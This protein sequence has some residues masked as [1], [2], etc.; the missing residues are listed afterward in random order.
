[1]FGLIVYIM[2]LALTGM[3]LLVGGEVMGPFFS[4][5]RPSVMKDFLMI[6]WPY[7]L[8]LIIFFISS[9]TYLRYMQKSKYSQIQENGGV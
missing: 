9:F 7:G 3:L 5:M 6:L 8:A 4:I 2:T 1:M